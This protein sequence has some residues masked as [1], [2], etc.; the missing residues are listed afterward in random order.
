MFCV[1]TKQST[2]RAE[3]M[4]Y[5][6]TNSPWFIN[7]TVKLH[8]KEKQFLFW[9]VFSQTSSDL[10]LTLGRCP[11]EQQEWNL[12]HRKSERTVLIWKRVK[13]TYQGRQRF[14]CSGADTVLV[15]FEN[16]SWVYS[17]AVNSLVGLCSYPRLWPQAVGRDWNNRIADGWK[18][19]YTCCN[20][21]SL[22]S[23]RQLCFIDICFIPAVTGGCRSILLNYRYGHLDNTST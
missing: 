14:I 1:S 9:L 8:V 20:S 19:Q 6:Q 10:H 23:A 13:G 11:A 22:R 7:R 15:C 17:R 21:R 4:G 5:K 18:L 2:H 3:Q 12:A 16:K